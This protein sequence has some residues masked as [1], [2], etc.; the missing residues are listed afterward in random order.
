[1][2]DVH[3]ALGA[4]NV[5]WASTACVD[6]SVHRKLGGSKRLDV[7]FAG[8]L[9]SRRAAILEALR[10][11]VP[12]HVTSIWDPVELNRLFNEA[13][14]VLNLHLSE[15]ANTETR[16]AEVLGA[17]TLLVTETLSSPSLV[18]PGR[19]VVEVETG[20]VEALVA[21]VRRALDDPTGHEAIAAAGHQHM[22]EKHTFETRLSTLIRR[23]VEI[24]R[25]RVLWPPSLGILH[26]QRGAETEDLRA[27]R[28]AVREDAPARR[29]TADS[30][31]PRTGSRAEPARTRIA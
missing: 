30:S 15:F 27:F 12:V 20:N 21:A 13:R 7:V 17:G 31:D 18:T 16:V 8:T 5:T 14:V 19:H 2:M 24:R 1:M 6:P 9:T 23:A 22:H 29:G 10:V 11:H 28:E 26:D 3:L 25:Q 4:A